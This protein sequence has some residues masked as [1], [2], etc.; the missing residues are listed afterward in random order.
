M[1][2]SVEDAQSLSQR[3]LAGLGYSA[4]QAAMIADHL[5]LN[6]MSGYSFAGLP[7]ILA[8]KDAKERTL[9]T[10]DL[11]IVSETP[12]SLQLD[13]GNQ[14]AY[15]ALTQ[16]VDLVLE[17]LKLSRVC[18][19]S[20]GNSWYAG[21]SFNYVEKLGRAGYAALLFISGPPLVAPHGAAKPLFGTNPICV[22]FPIDPDPII[23]DLGTSAAMAGEV[24]LHAMLGKEMPPGVGMGP[25]GLPTQNAAEIV[26]GAILPLAG[27]KG[28]ALSFAVQ[29]LGL[30]GATVLPQDRRD[31]FGYLLLAF[32][33]T[34]LC[35]REAF[36]TALAELREKIVQLPRAPGFESIE[37]PSDRT[38]RNRRNAQAGIEVDSDVVRRLEVL[39]EASSGN[40]EAVPIG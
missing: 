8:I 15:I 35:P 37:V 23:V 1:R 6:A 14:V 2:L 36:V 40:V 9:P 10:Q 34:L 17:K 28:S 30:F 11:R 13:G 21:R 25:D 24:F 4:E 27:H 12:V 20:M 16:A 7:R 33:P 26:K 3:A 22:A 5:V 38:Y 29:A 19:M 32:D 18:L 39:A 31:G